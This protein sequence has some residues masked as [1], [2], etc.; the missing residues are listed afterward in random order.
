[1]KVWAWVMIALLGSGIGLLTGF[2]MGRA[3][4]RAIPVH[5]L[6][7]EG[8]APIDADC[9]CPPDDPGAAQ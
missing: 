5:R 3:T 1:M 8:M 7:D 9:A 4:A 6:G 2:A